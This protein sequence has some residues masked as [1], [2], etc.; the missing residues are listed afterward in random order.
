MKYLWM[1]AVCVLIGGVFGAGFGITDIS[2]NTTVNGVTNLS[3]CS[4]DL[5]NFGTPANAARDLQ[6]LG[7]FYNE[8]ENMTYW[9][10]LDGG[11]FGGSEA[12]ILSPFP[13]Y[14]FTD[15]NISWDGV[16]AANGIDCYYD[17]AVVCADS[18]NDFAGVTLDF[19]EF[20]GMVKP[21]NS[22]LVNSTLTY[23]WSGI[24][25]YL[26]NDDIHM[27]M[28]IP[29]ILPLVFY[30]NPSQDY[31]M[32]AA[33]QGLGTCKTTDTLFDAGIT[34]NAAATFLINSGYV[35]I[36]EAHIGTGAHL[37]NS[38][39][40]K[41]WTFTVPYSNFTNPDT[42]LYGAYIQF[43]QNPSPL[44]VFD[45]VDGHISSGY[46]GQRGG[47]ETTPIN[48][49]AEVIS[50]SC[51]LSVSAPY[52]GGCV[53][54]SD[55]GPAPVV[56]GSLNLTE[57]GIGMS[58]LFTA[59]ENPLPMLIYGLGIAIAM[60]MFVLAIGFVVKKAMK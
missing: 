20:G 11:A 48:I 32:A 29:M 10:C 9:L 38:T 13:T 1:I 3:M 42:D 18:L 6:V 23:S 16:C 52:D 34:D 19:L 37:I 33:R 51:D 54:F 17:S 28:E 41:M 2:I 12:E 56:P 50:T 25:G 30:R 7:R 21:G 58:G 26:V 44:I 5:F 47:G 8:T 45:G 46:N 27:T 43:N 4:D 35:T 36:A 53:R 14:H 31:L 22:D 55:I 49:T 57:I 15:S 60:I 39:S 40:R 24:G 59:L